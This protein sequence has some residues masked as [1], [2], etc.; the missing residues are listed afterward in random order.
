NQRTV[1]RAAGILG[2]ISIMGPHADRSPL[3]AQ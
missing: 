1:A 2:L 3:V